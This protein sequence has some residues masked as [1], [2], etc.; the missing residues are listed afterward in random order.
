M[1]E[2]HRR[3][4]PLV[5]HLSTSNTQTWIMFPRRTQLVALALALSLPAAVHAEDKGKQA[6]Q[7]YLQLDTIAASVVRPNGRHGVLTV[8]VGLD[9]GDPALR[10]KLELYQPMLRSAYV[11]ALQ[12][13]ALGISPGAPPNADYIAAVLQRE[14][15]R[16]LGR[17][18][19]RL[20]VG[21]ILIN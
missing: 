21:S 15:D 17:R 8:E 4:R 5:N 12:P 19:A 3:A 7:P 2:G 11:S 18:G 6:K 10:D 9:A 1:D 13:Y 14:T 16:V 20:L